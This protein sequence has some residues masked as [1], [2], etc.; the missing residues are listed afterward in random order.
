MEIFWEV[1]GKILSL[2]T[3]FSS[4]ITLAIIYISMLETTSGVQALFEKQT[5]GFK[6]TFRY[7]RRIYF[8]FTDRFLY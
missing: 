1:S 2:E 4:S 7:T 3:D 8:I 5:C 6:L